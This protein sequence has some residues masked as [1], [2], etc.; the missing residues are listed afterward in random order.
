MKPVR[1]PFGSDD[2][3][4]VRQ[5]TIERADDL[6]IRQ[7]WALI[8]DAHHLPSGVNPLIRA[9]REH[10]GDVARS[11]ELAK[12]SFQFAL[13]RSSVALPL[14]SEELPPI[15]RDRQRVDDPAIRR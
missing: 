2:G 14:R 7:V 3:K 13:N 4:I 1:L 10:R 5:E 6:A 8:G 15:V 9:P 11:P 12:C